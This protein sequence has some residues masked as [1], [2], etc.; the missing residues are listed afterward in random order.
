MQAASEKL[1]D[2]IGRLQDPSINWDDEFAK[3]ESKRW[4]AWFALTKGRLLATRARQL[5]YLAVTDVAA[6]TLSSE[7]NSF[8]LLPSESLRVPASAALISE[9]R[10]CLGRCIEDNPGTPW[11]EMATWEACASVWTSQSAGKDS[12][13]IA[14]HHCRANKNADDVHVPQICKASRLGI[15]TFRDRHL[16]LLAADR[17]LRQLPRGFV[18]QA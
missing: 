18:T 5:E 11:E 6:S 1:A 4:R 10:A 13:A 15:R 2:L 9:A 16:M 14:K 8:A 12:Q 3:E 7:S 17:S